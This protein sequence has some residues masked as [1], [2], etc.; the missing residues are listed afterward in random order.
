MA[1]APVRSRKLIGWS[2]FNWQ[3]RAG[4]EQE[5]GNGLHGYGEGP[6]LAAYARSSEQYEWAAE[7]AANGGC[8]IGHYLSR[9]DGHCYGNSGASL[10]SRPDARR[11]ALR[12]TDNEPTAESLPR[13]LG[14]VE[15]RW[16]G[17]IAGIRPTEPFRQPRSRQKRHVMRLLPRSNCSS[18]GCTWSSIKSADGRG[19]FLLPKPNLGVRPRQ[20]QI[21]ATRP[22]AVAFSLGCDLSRSSTT[23][24]LP[25]L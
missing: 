5:F 8:R 14:D 21:A 25:Q 10:C 16:P 1:R 6:R 20:G 24:R 7:D 23:L 17:A 2:L 15:C 19:R 4:E 12:P 11:P 22:L 13:R 18:T 3:H 9:L